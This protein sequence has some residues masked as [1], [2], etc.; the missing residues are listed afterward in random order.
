[1][2]ALMQELRSCECHFIRCIKPNEEKKPGL[3][4]GSLVLQQIRYLGVLESIKVR[5]ES[6]PMRRPYKLF[7]QK[8]EDLRTFSGT[9][10]IDLKDLADFKDLTRKLMEGALKNYP[11]EL[12]L[13]G[14]TKIFLRNKTFLLIEK[15]YAEKMEEKNTKALRIQRAFYRFKQMRKIRQI[16]KA[17][18][19]FKNFWKV[20][21]EYKHF[22]KMRKAV[23]KI[24]HFYKFRK[25]H[26][27]N[28]KKRANCMIIQNYMRR[29]LIWK[30][31]EGISLAEKV[32]IIVRN[33]RKWI[34]KR[35][36]MRDKELSEI[37]LNEILEKAW[38][39]ILNIKATI[40]QKYAR[41]YLVIMKNYEIVKKA[42]KAK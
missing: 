26:S 11:E 24:Q 21:Q 6:F 16:F 35:K 30:R 39:S 2:K 41:R 42:R 13:Y 9:N 23:R 38:I 32:K 12:V 37:V 3:W 15:M 40:I 28:I 27:D 29:Y 36:I 4:N 33:L 20:R 31:F 8:Y 10:F 7:Y 5:K 25:N 34:L 1:M 17:L 14:K 19:R 18:K 22:R